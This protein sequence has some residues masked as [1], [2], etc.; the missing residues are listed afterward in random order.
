MKTLEEQI[1]AMSERWPGFR[2]VERADERSAEWQGILTPDKR[3]HLV[4]IRY[5]APMLL[6]NITTHDAQP[7]VQVLKALLE[8]HPD[9]EE[10]PLPHV[11]G[12]RGQ[13]EL[14]YLCLFS[15]T[16][17]EWGTNDLIADTTVFWTAEWLYFYEGWLVTKRWQGGGQ[18][19]G[20][21][22]GAKTIETV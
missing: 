5:R 13:P 19:I 6:E 9:Y 15:S 22:G 3:E 16:N 14:P 11:Y 17:R 7:R 2:L 8:R 4:R 21:D 1:H 10:G 18:H 12:N 20:R